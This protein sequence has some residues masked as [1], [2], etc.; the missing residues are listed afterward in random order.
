MLFAPFTIIDCFRKIAYGSD[1]IEQ[2]KI[3]LLND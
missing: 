2:G 3:I 1:S